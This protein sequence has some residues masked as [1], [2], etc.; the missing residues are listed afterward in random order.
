LG[1]S[2]ASVRT[3][4]GDV[5]RG[6]SPLCTCLG[7]E[8][9]IVASQPRQ[10]IQHLLEDEVKIRQKY[11]WQRQPLAKFTE[12]LRSAATEGRK[13]EKVI[14]QLRAALLWVNL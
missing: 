9:L 5:V 14:S 4:E 11:S 8:V 10:E 2:G 6:G 1:S 3:N 7:D 12:T 13:T